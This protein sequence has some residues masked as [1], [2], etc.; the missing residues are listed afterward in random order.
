MFLENLPGY[1]EGAQIDRIDNN[2]HYSPDNVRWVTN[3]EN[4][5]NKSTNVTIESLAEKTRYHKKHICDRHGWDINGFIKVRIIDKPGMYIY[6]AKN[7][8]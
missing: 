5:M 7:K 3:A 1:F 8:L 4:Q 2:G 6:I